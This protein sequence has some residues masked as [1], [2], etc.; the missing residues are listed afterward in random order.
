MFSE[1]ML[2]TGT[3]LSTGSMEVRDLG[4]FKAFSVL[5]KWSDIS[6]YMYLLIYP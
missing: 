1:H 3:M 5:I 4:S 6:V 2:L